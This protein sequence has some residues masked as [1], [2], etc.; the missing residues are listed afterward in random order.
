MLS[1]VEVRTEKTNYSDS[2]DVSKSSS[3]SS[4]FISRIQQQQV[5]KSFMYN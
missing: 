5:N 4:S 3:S 2:P 1:P